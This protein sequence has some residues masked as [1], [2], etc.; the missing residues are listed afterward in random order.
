MTELGR[1][2][3]AVIIE[4]LKKYN[5][6]SSE[7][8]IRLL[9]MVAAH[10]SGGFKYVKQIRGPAVSLFQI[11]P[12]TLKDLVSHV[13][14][15]KYTLPKCTPSDL[16]FNVSL[17][18]GYARVFFLRFKDPVP[19]KNDIMGMARYAKRYWNTFKGKATVEDYYNA[20]RRY[21][22]SSKADD[23]LIHGA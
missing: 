18:V 19:D 2:C 20:Y 17:S 10:E 4:S 21:F 6:P 23:D 3:R 8:A 9:S 22:G 11:D 16:I 1:G 14:T 5:L 7:A 13:E 12:D 15:K